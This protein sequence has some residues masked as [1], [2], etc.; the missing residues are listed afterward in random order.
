MLVAVVVAQRLKAQHAAQEAQ[1]AAEMAGH[2][3]ITEP[4]VQPTQAAAVV[5]VATVLL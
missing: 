5:A 1:A 3:E 2:L 4:L